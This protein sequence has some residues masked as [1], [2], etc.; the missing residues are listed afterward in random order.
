MFHALG[1]AT[2]AGCLL[3]TAAGAAESGALPAELRLVG[4]WDRRTPDR[5]ITVN[6]GSFAL[7]RFAGTGATARFD[8]S[9]NKPPLPTIAWRIDEGE[10]QEAEIAAQVA[11]GEN[12]A[13]G[14]H[15]VMLMARGLDE[16]QRRWSPPL[17]ASITL[18]SA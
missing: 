16:H 3:I 4:R 12:L 14:P 17:V 18:G 9:V 7:A 10:W 1:L 15:T 6:S 5:A 13:A 2:L 8:L 11:L